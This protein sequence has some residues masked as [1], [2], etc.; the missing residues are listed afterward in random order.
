MTG[1]ITRYG[2]TLLSLFFLSGLLAP[3]AV[4]QTSGGRAPADF[5]SQTWNLNPKSSFVYIQSVKKGKLFETHQF[6]AVDGQISKD[7]AAR[8]TIELASLETNIDIRNV[9]MRFLLFETFKFPNAVITAQLDKGKLRD[10]LNRTRTTYPLKLKLSLHGITKTIETNV[11]ATRIYAN[12]VSVSSTKPI[13]INAA[14]FGLAG[15]IAKLAEAAGGISIVPA[16]SISFDFVFEGA[17]YNPKVEAARAALTKR[18][19]AIATRRMDKTACATRL[20]VI[21]KTR[22]IYFRSG[23]A[24]LDTTSAP[25]LDRLA[26]IAQRCPDVTI[27]VAG[28]TDSDGSSAANKRLSDARARAVARYLTQRGVGAERL[29]AIGRGDTQPVVPNTSSANKAKNRRIEFR[30]SS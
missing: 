5:F 13:I 2:L 8:I 28:H 20:K 10:L 21:S 15:G 24:K 12:A 14:D 16:A 18:R 6:Q 11:L 9:R 3:A 22:A 4:A 26:D 25:L 23:S 30:I 19:A 7:G 17:N 1:R 29:R 27:E